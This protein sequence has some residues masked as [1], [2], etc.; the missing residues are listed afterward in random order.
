LVFPYD[1]LDKMIR[2]D[3]E[4]PSK[5]VLCLIHLLKV[6]IPLLC[7]KCATGSLEMEPTVLS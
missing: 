4:P 2:K 6:G 7:W 5:W 3:R 1:D